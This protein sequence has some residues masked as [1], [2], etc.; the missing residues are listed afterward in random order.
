MGEEELRTRIEIHKVRY[1]KWSWVLLAILISW[2]ATI[3]KD[4]N[5]SIVVGGAIMIIFM[6]KLIVDYSKRRGRTHDKICKR[7]RPKEK[8]QINMVGN[9]VDN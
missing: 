5:L 7:G 2:I 9:M 3:I 8:Q 4:S 1:D 6:S